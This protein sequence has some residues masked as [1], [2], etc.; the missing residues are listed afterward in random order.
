[1]KSGSLISIQPEGRKSRKL[2]LLLSS[3]QIFISR[4]PSVSLFLLQLGRKKF[5]TRPFLV[6][7]APTPENGLDRDSAGNIL[8][9]RSVSIERFIGQIGQLENER[10]QELLAG[11]VICIEYEPEA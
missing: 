1:M 4:S 5:I 2:V 9:V 10:L 8:Q 7:I 11:L 6:K 3:V